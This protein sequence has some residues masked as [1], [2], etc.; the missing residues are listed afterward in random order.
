MTFRNHTVV[1]TLGLITAL[2]SCT[3]EFNDID[4]QML[5]G[6]SFLFESESFGVEVSHQQTGVVRTDNLGLYQLGHIEDLFF[7]R[8]S[9]QY[10]T[11]ISL[12]TTGGDSFGSASA[13]TE[14]EGIQTTSADTLSVDR[15]VHNEQETVTAVWLEIPYVTNQRDSDGDGVIDVLD[16]DPD[17]RDSDTDGDNL[18]D[19]EES[20]N[21]NLNPLEADT[22]GDGINDDVDEDTVHPD[23]G[24][25]SYEIDLLYGNAEQVH[26]KVHKSDYYL[27][28]LDPN[29]NFEQEQAYFSD[30]DLIQ[31]GLAP[32]VLFDGNVTLDF[33][34]IITYKEDDPGTEDVNESEEVDQRLTPRLRIPLQNTSLFQDILDKEGASELANNESFQ[35]YFQGLV[36]GIDES[37]PMLM[38]LNFSAGQ[39][40][41]EYDYQKLVLKEEGDPS[42]QADYIVEEASG[43]LSLPMSGIS[44]NTFAQTGFSA[45]VSSAVSGNDNQE[46]IYLKGGPGVMAQIDLFTGTDGQSLL[47]DLQTRPWLINEANLILYVDRDKTALMGDVAQPE[48]LYL[49]DATN[50]LPIADYS[51][52]DSTGTYSDQIKT[53]YGGIPQLDDSNNIVSYKFRVTKHLSNLLRNPEDFENVAL[54][55]SVSSNILTTANTTTSDE[56]EVPAAMIS[57]PLGTILAGPNHSNP[58]LR[59]KLEVFYTEYEQ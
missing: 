47:E 6:S 34:E 41:V 57:N 19:Y 30:F 35:G 32:T 18:T 13:E 44:F 14:A 1:L 16:V 10:T 58:D 38:Q 24:A 46:N 12:P 42:K 2:L 36:L 29:A 28:T 25:N 15:P 56:R 7:G 50:H 21:P 31:Q 20:I 49:F 43:S 59:L 48:R 51:T 5:P 4:P 27:R 8:T 40:R 45:E 9:A 39:L 54:G 37:I 3:K 53:N 55:L 52:D 23:S 11:Q 22:D 33:K 17:D 26:F